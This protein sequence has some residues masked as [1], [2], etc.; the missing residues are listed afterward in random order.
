MQEPPG[1]GERP[2]RTTLHEGVARGITHHRPELKTQPTEVPETQKQMP[3]LEKS[4]RLSTKKCDMFSGEINRLKGRI[5]KRVTVQIEG[6]LEEATLLDTIRAENCPRRTG[7]SI[8]GRGR[9]RQYVQAQG[10]TVGISL[11]ECRRVCP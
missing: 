1:R 4:L 3:R 8:R 7:S 2:L 9:R 10:T 6:R 11:R 5:E